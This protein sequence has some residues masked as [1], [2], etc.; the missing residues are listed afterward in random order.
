MRTV[1]RLVLVCGLAV[2]LAGPALAQPPQRG[3]GPGFGGG[4]D[5][6]LAN[7]GVQ[8]EL[9]LT[10]EQIQK[11]KT[12][13]ES[14][15]EKRREAFGK[16]RDLG[17]EERR[18]KMQEMMKTMTD[19]TMK[20]AEKI[21]KPEQVTRLKQIMLQQRNVQ[22]IIDDADVQK[23]LKLTDEQKEKLKTIAGDMAQERREIFQN[24]QGNFEE[25]MKKM[26]SLNKETMEKALSVL[27][28]EQKTAY[29]GLTGEPFE[30]RFQP[31]RRQP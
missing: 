20:E 18:E 11:I 9:K 26:Q 15:G 27:S 30:V 7:E 16:L 1:G 10:D 19:Q 3:G 22:G 29:K 12:F 13:V 6:L 4:P 28:A 21:L 17:P 8:K 23:T 14:M 31:P 2:L 24:A 25:A 5:M